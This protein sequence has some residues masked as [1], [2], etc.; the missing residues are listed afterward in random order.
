MLFKIFKIFKIE[1]A[2]HCFELFTRI[3]IRNTE[4]KCSAS[5]CFLAKGA[6]RSDDQNCPNATL[7]MIHHWMQST[8]G[9]IE[10]F[11]RQPAVAVATTRCMELSAC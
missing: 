2:I 3:G 5:V 4:A 7:V 1:N 6:S 10:M 8:L 11:S 9:T